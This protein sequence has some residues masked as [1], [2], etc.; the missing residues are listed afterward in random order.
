RVKLTRAG[1]EF[2][3]C[4]PFH[5]EKTPSF[6]VND[7]KGFFHCF[8]CGA[9]GDAVSFRMRHDNLGFMEAV[10]GLASEAGMEIPKPDPRSAEKFD[11]MQRLMQVMERVSKWFEAQLHHP[12]NGFALRYLKDRGLSD[13]TIARF[14]LGFAP[15]S[16]DVARDA[17]LQQNLK[18]DD[19][20]NL[21][22]LKRS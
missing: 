18:I 4:C 3:A 7:D 21:G 12:Q 5:N 14:R 20:I 6:Y 9:H 19:L 11:E 10:E 15:N 2:K 8:G 1:R 16:W 13:E 17:W 22:L